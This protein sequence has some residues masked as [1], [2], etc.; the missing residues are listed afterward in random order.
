MAK[1]G[2]DLSDW[3]GS[4]LGKLR[5]RPAVRVPFD[6]DALAP[7]SRSPK[8][9]LHVNA[10]CPASLAQ[11]EDVVDTFPGPPLVPGRPGPWTCVL[12]N[13][14]NSPIR[15]LWDGKCGSPPKR[16]TG[17]TTA[18]RDLSLRPPTGNFTAPPVLA[19]S[20]SSDSYASRPDVALWYSASGCQALDNGRLGS[21]QGANR[22]F[23]EFEEAMNKLAPA[24]PESSGSL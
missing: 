6:R 7:L 13:G 3:N 10:G 2:D 4:C 18:V 15:G 1:G 16:R 23:G 20:H 11:Y 14:S 8:L 12:V 21:F 19:R 5:H 17:W 22:S 24:F 9:S